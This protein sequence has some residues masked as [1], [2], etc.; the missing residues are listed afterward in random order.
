[1]SADAL[2]E[3]EVKVD[4]MISA[5]TMHEQR[6]FTDA[7]DTVTT[8]NRFTTRE[9]ADEWCAFINGIA[10]ANSITILSTRVIDVTQPD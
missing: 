10:T 6:G 7:E 9:Y 8:L 3:I 2:S 1:M 5:G 4:T